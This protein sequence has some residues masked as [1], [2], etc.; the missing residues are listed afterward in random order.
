MAATTQQQRDEWLA[1]Y[2]AIARQW[3][4]VCRS[5]EYINQRTKLEFSCQRGHLFSAQPVNVYHKGSWCPHCSG[6]AKLSLQDA[7]VAAEALGCVCL[8]TEYQSVHKPLQWRCSRG[9]AFTASLTSVRTMGACCM[10]CQ[11]LELSEFERL[12]ESIG[13]TLLSDTYTNNYTHIRLLC[14]VGHLLT[15]QPKHLKEG[16]RCGECAAGIR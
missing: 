4:G 6:N 7:H 12:A 1:K 14:D 11:K 13:Y 3:G 2:Q 15:I 5:T 16:R 8:S 10:A 9:H